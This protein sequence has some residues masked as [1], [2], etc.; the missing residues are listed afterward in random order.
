M[1]LIVWVEVLGTG[2]YWGLKVLECG[3]ILGSTGAVSH[4]PSVLSNNSSN[5]LINPG[6]SF[7]SSGIKLVV[8]D[9]TLSILE[10]SKVLFNI[11]DSPLSY[12]PS[13]IHIFGFHFH[14]LY[15]PLGYISIICP[16]AWLFRVHYFTTPNPNPTIQLNCN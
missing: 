4:L 15:L 13:G 5:L 6:N 7:L 11:W 14:L 10:F 3:L 9:A 16:V 8:L 1:Y 2:Y 12:F